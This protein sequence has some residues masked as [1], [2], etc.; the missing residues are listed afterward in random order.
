M[1]THHLEIVAIESLL[2]YLLHS[3]TRNTKF[4]LPTVV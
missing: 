3:V 1:L 4:R 2:N